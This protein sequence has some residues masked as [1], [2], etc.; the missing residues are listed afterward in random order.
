[1]P[2]RAPRLGAL[3]LLAAL[4]ALSASPTSLEAKEPAAERGTITFYVDGGATS[5]GRYATALAAARAQLVDMNVRLEVA[6]GTDVADVRERMDRIAVAPRKGDRMLAAVW[7]DLRP[8]GDILV[9]VADG[10]ARRVLVRRVHLASG[11]EGA[12]FEEM[13]VI[14]R[15][16]VGALLEGHAIGMEPAPS[17]TVA[18]AAAKPPAPAPTSPPPQPSAPAT[19]QAPGARVD[20]VPVPAQ[21]KSVL[22]PV[23][24]VPVRPAAETSTS[25]PAT[26]EDQAPPNP[27][28]RASR[29]RTEAL[30]LGIAYVGGALA[31]GAGW[32]SGATFSA[33]Y[34][35]PFGAYGSLSYD[36]YATASLLASGIEIELARHPT[37]LAVGYER[38]LFDGR[39]RLTGELGLMADAI[40]RSAV[41]G[42][43]FVP[44]SDAT[45]VVW[46]LGPRARIAVR[47]VAPIW[48]AVG[49]GLDV[50]LTRFDYVVSPS[51]PVLELDTVRPRLEL[52]LVGAVF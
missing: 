15:S 14:V 16:T 19:A 25:P 27:E 30:R 39:M 9:F 41:A 21:P 38:T 32:Q 8:P 50:V 22:P 45:R 51:V 31:P 40:Q 44:T 7:L 43:G 37:T 4:L 18:D 17:G 6:P 23:T 20:V 49:A 28:S 5:A 48:I 34:V 1:M 11:A 2:P 46:S 24:P 47:L 26:R 42:P 36:A 33:G 3:R 12:A 29:H 13:A 10:N 35:A 52:G